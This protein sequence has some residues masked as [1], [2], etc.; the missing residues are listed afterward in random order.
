[1][2]DLSKFTSVYYHKNTGRKYLARKLDDYSIQVFDVERG[3]LTNTTR[4]FLKDEFSFCKKESKQ[5]KFGKLK[6]F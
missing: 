3:T 6:R 2:T 1:M 4:N 5:Y